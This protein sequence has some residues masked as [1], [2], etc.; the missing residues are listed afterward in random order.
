[1]KPG[2]YIL[3]PRPRAWLGAAL[4]ALA[5]VNL[6]AAPKPATPPPTEELLIPQSIFVMP[7]SPQEGRDP[8]FPRSN[9]PY[10]SAAVLHTN[11]APVVGSAPAPTPA[12]LHLKGV[13]GTAARPL[14]IINNRTFAVGEQGDVPTPTG[15]LRIRV[16]EIRRDGHVVVQTSSDIVVLSLPAGF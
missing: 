9:R 7:T 13:S 6:D 4:S 14:A 15:R 12:D 8:F 10:M 1:M 16:V 2:F 3:P 5:L 11:V